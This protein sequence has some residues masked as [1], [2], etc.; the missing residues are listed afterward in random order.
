MT[1]AEVILHPALREQLIGEAMDQVA[2]V[3][4]DIEDLTQGRTLP[5]EYGGEF[6]G[7]DGRELALEALDIALGLA[8]ARVEQLLDGAS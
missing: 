3:E 5:E 2:A 8:R 6:T 7:R 4:M 1:D